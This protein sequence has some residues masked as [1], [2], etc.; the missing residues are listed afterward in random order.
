MFGLKVLLHNITLE[1]KL[2]ICLKGDDPSH[3]EDSNSFGPVRAY[4]HSPLLI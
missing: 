4:I 1:R 2:N 3:S